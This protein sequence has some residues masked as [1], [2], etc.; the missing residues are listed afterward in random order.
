MSPGTLT[1]R[2]RDKI[3]STLRITELFSSGDGFYT[4]PFKV[5]YALNGTDRSRFL[6]SVP[7]R[8]FKRAVKRNYI[9]RLVRECLRTSKFCTCFENGID[10][11]L[12]YTTS[13]IPDYTLINTKIENVLV[14]IKKRVETDSNTTADNID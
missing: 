8:N 2:K 5:C 1:L 4:H 3:C 12:V 10:V 7:K 6:I 13:D 9:K 14:K 11:C